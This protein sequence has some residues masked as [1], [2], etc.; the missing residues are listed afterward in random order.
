MTPL[1][2]I[3]PRGTAQID[4]VSAW[5]PPSLDTPGRMYFLNISTT[6]TATIQ[7]TYT[8]VYSAI[9][10]LHKQE[11]EVYVFHSMSGTLFVLNMIFVT[12][13]SSTISSA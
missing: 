7:E 11:Q 4:D 1:V 5:L 12:N 10:D 13:I 2:Y 9:I 8:V 6:S 3:M